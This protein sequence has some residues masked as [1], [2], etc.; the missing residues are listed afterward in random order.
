MVFHHEVS[1]RQSVLLVLVIDSM[2]LVVSQNVDVILDR[3]Y[4]FD[5]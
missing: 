2:Q 5:S 1:L 3:I 4:T